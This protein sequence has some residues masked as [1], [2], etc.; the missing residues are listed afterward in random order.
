[1]HTEIP[2]VGQTCLLVIH[3]A[4]CDLLCHALAAVPNEEAYVFAV[5]T[6]TIILPVFALLVNCQNLLPHRTLGYRL[7][8]SLES[9][10]IV[11]FLTITDLRSHFIIILTEVE[12]KLSPAVLLP[13]RK[14]MSRQTADLLRCCFFLLVPSDFIVAGPSH[15]TAFFLIFNCFEFE[16]RCLNQF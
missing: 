13:K 12:Q 7:K 5:L 14:L 16:S 2:N 8:T 1:M 11:F 15:R 6:K 9:S 3:Q 10:L 4:R